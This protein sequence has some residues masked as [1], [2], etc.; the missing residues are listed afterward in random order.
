MKKKHKNA[1][2]NSF[3]FWW[4]YGYKLKK[5]TAE[6]TPAVSDCFLVLNDQFLGRNLTVFKKNGKKIDTIAEKIGWE[7]WK[8]SNVFVH[9]N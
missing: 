3:I 6:Y 7:N 4:F 5:E 9:W 8:C 1:V 2:Q